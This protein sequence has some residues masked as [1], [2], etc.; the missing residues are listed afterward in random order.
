MLIHV[1]DTVELWV[2]DSVAV[3]VFIVEELDKVSSVVNTS[4]GAIGE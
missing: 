4:E 1:E 2:G 3:V